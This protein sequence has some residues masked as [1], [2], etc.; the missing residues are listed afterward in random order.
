MNNT[1]KK[2]APTSVIKNHLVRMHAGYEILFPNPT[3]RPSYRTFNKWKAQS[4]FPF[5]KIGGN[6]LIDPVEVQAALKKRFTVPAA[7]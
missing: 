4:Y 2:Y 7:R 5:L 3:E 6:V 1:Q